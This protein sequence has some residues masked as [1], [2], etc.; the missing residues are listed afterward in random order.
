ML[1]PLH[2][3]LEA[4]RGKRIAIVIGARTTQA[5]LLQRSGSRFNLLNYTLTDTPAVGTDNPLHRTDIFAPW[6]RISDTPNATNE[7]PEEVLAEHLKKTLQGLGSRSTEAILV[8]GM[9]EILLRTAELPT[10]NMDQARQVL[11]LNGRS[12]VQ[13]EL[14]DYEIDAI[15]LGNIAQEAPTSHS[16]STKLDFETDDSSPQPSKKQSKQ[17]V[18]IGAGRK[19]MVQHLLTAVDMVGIQVNHITFTQTSLVNVARL[20]TPQTIAEEVVGVL[21]LGFKTSTISIL[22]G[23]H[24]LLTR[25]VSAGADQMSQD[26]ADILGIKYAAAEGVKTLMP[27]KVEPKLKMLLSALTTEFRAAI[28]FFEDQESKTVSRIFVAGGSARSNFIIEALRT[29]LGRPCERLDLSTFLDLGLTQEKK[30]SF[31]KDAPQLAAAIGAA[32]TWTVPDALRLNLLIEEQKKREERRRDPVRRASLAASMIVT[33]MLAWWLILRVHTF[34]NGHE[35]K[36]EQAKLETL[37]KV[38]DLVVKYSK[39]AGHNERS[40]E[41]LKEHGMKRA[42]WANA[43]NALQQVH[44]DGVQTVR[45]SMKEAL[46]KPKPKLKSAVNPAAV[47]AAVVAALTPGVEAPPPV[48][49]PT[50]TPTENKPEPFIARLSIVI[51]ARNAADQEARD[52]YIEGIIRNP[53]FRST[54]REF[55]P[56]VLTS[57]Q[58]RQVDPLDPE[59][60]FSLFTVECTFR[61]QILGY[62]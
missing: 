37:K 10:M 58:A 31:A 11:S 60:S 25:A 48:P 14:A 22:V 28:D 26:L 57:R 49:K 38:V 12:Y 23:G 6:T 2:S 51:V 59:R 45:I 41:A 32:V 18:L 62:E 44:V 19:L 17:R 39:D 21:D 4:L 50:T 55:N 30:D 3:R 42:A 15:S 24:P 52:R 8:V 29:E 54:L 47:A 61:D 5:V 1:E 7:K 46:I 43:L 34:I 13:Q 33:I 27:E 56:V 16:T 40:T 53:Y 35:I 36:R 20:V 9:S